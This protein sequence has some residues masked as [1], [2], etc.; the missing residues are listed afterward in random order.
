MLNI[1]K[2][3]YWD[4][5]RLS[6]VRVVV[7]GSLAFFACITDTQAVNIGKWKRFDVSYHNSSWSGNPYDLNFTGTFTHATSGRTLTQFGFYAGDNTWKLYFMPD[8]LGNW[9]FTTSS[10]D[11]D[12]NNK[13]GSF[14]CVSSGLPGKLIAQGKRWKNSDGKFVSPIMLPSG[15]YI[16]GNSLGITSAFVNWAKNTAG[17]QIIGTTLLNFKG[18]KN[19]TH[20]QEDRMY[21]DSAEGVEFYQP[22]WDR[23]NLFYDYLRDSEMGHYILIFSDDGSNPNK[24]GITANSAA[25]LRLFKYLVARFAPY[26]MVIWDSGIDIGET[27]DNS[28]INNFVA[29]FHDNDPWKHPIASR[30]GGGSGGIHPAE[31]DYYSDGFKDTAFYNNFINAWNKRSVPTAYTDRWR[32][33]GSRGGPPD[34][35]RKSVWESAVAGGQALY[36]TAN[37]DFGYLEDTYATDLEVAPQLGYRTKFIDTQINNFG[38]LNPANELILSGS[39]VRLAAN[40][41]EEYLVYLGSGGSTKID[42]SGAPSVSFEIVWLNPKTGIVQTSSNVNGGGSTTFTSPFSQ[43]AVLLLRSD[44]D[45]LSVPEAP[46]GLTATPN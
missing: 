26:P 32:E 31:A 16:R 34:D 22:S 21:L 6:A 15:P 8:E 37:E 40:P 39:N 5:I 43:E 38:Q 14:T 17:A 11:P 3:N 33:N 19:Y 7:L 18:D 10:S 2:N 27:R 42:L 30:T 23:S 20:S 24:H 9:T 45:G 29:W 28:W 44:N 41:G 36:I 1:K 4:L 12:L 25:E 46:S 13:S 35:L